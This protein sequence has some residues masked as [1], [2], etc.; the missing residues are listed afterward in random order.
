MQSFFKDTFS[1]TNNIICF[2]DMYFENT[3]V[4]NPLPAEQGSDQYI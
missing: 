2:I 3:S 1:M 4:I